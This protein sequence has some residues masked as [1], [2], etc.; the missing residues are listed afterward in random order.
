MFAD[1]PVFLLLVLAGWTDWR[2]RKIANKLVWPFLISGL[3]VQ[4]SEGNG[5]RSLVGL[6]VAFLLT[7]LPVLCRGMGMGDQKLLMAVGAWTGGGE[8]YTLFIYS[9]CSC[10]FAALLMPTRWRVLLYNLRLAAIGW[11]SH[12]MLWLPSVE[13]SA[14]AIPYAVHLLFAFLFIKMAEVLK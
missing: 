6:C 5:W 1:A 7:V 8:V 11:V 13:K 10:I 9:L 2:K 4:T 14:W 12:R 3:L